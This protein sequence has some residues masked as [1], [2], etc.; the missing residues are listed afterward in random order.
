MISRQYEFV[1]QGKSTY[2]NLNIKKQHF[3]INR[4]K[5]IN[6]KLKVNIDNHDI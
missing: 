3:I 1:S 2:L 6:M 4:K 5:G